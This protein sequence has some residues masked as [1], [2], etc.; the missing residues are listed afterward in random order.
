MMQ[1]ALAL[2]AVHFIIDLPHPVK[3]SPLRTTRSDLSISRPETVWT[4]RSSTR[5]IVKI[6]PFPSM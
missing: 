6:S 1:Y 3:T 2:Y 4:P 5:K